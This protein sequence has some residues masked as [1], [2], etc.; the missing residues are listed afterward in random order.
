MNN[1]IKSDAYFAPTGYTQ[2]GRIKVTGYFVLRWEL[3]KLKVEC[4]YFD[5]DEYA[6]EIA[7]WERQGI[8]GHI[9]NL[10]R[11]LELNGI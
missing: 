11:S 2:D 6:T 9:M 10:L 5:S 1:V 8:N 4:P 3:R 7:Y